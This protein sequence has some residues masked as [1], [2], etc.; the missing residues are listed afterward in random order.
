MPLSVFDAFQ[1]NAP[2]DFKEKCP[3]IHSGTIEPMRIKDIFTKKT[4]FY[5]TPAFQNISEAH[6]DLEFGKEV[7]TAK[8]VDT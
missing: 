8:I 5:R 7:K 6:N 1:I 4:F 3:Y 2:K